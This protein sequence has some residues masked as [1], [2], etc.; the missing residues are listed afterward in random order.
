MLNSLETKWRYPLAAVLG[1]SIG[2]VIGASLATIYVMAVLGYDL[3]GFR[4]TEPW[5]LSDLAFPVSTRPAI[6]RLAWLITLLPIGVAALFGTASMYNGK[7]NQYDNAHFQSRRE[8]SRNR[9][10]AP[11]AR[12]G[13]I[14]GK[15]SKPKRAGGFISATPDRFPHAMMIAPT[16]RGKGVGFVLPNLLHFKGS[17]IVLDVKGE[18][19]RKTAHH[20]GEVQDGKV[21]YFSPYD[22][23]QPDGEDG[24]VMTRTHRFNPLARI[25]K[26]ASPEQQYTAINTM[27]DLFL[28]AQSSGAESFF[29]SGRS[30]F[31][32][33]CLHAIEIGRPTIGTAF[34]IMSGHGDKKAS[35]LAIAAK[36]A[37]DTVASIFLTMANETDKILDSFISVIR[38]A[39]L[40]LWKDPAVDRATSASDFDFATFRKEAQT[41]YIVVQPE[42]LTTLAPLI[43]L[44]FADAIA[45]LQSSERG[46]DEPHPVM[47][48]MDEFD[49]LGRQPIVLQS[50]K[51]IRSYGGRFFIISQSIPGLDAIYGQNDRLALQAGAG[52]QI[53]MT[54]QE[55][56]T[57]EVLSSALGKHTVVSRTNSR[58]R[59]QKLTESGSVSN[60]SEERALRSKAELLR[61]PLDKVLILPEGQQP[62]LAHHIRYYE[63][64]HFRTVARAGAG[65]PLP[66]PEVRALE[67]MSPASSSANGLDDLP[68]VASITLAQTEDAKTQTT[69]YLK[70][71]DAAKV[72]AMKL[73]SVRRPPARMT[74]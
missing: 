46:P 61:F 57:A 4:M 51:T 62:I 22:Y 45:R 37:N 35:Y 43:R 67:K 36:T 33:A 50:I 15:L 11:L 18:N 60:R 29:Q 48:L 10:I 24:P 65:R 39:G 20:R 17:A 42:H 59:V 34:D 9:M 6:E 41:L 13:F 47:F 40:G 30:L 53:Y 69:E 54:P 26:M 70:I 32:A 23:V 55:E 16:G 38:G 25:A 21:W 73:K 31:V 2:A 71:R 8:L 27:T 74:T 1:A 66:Y 68:P 49:Q 14:F 58:S 63:D 28:Q 5:F 64:Q 12:N 56:R 3:N 44:L 72:D 52:V 7:L 19:F